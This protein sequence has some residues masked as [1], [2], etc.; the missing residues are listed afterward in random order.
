MKLSAITRRF[1]GLTITSSGSISWTNR[2]LSTAILTF[3]YSVPSLAQE[4]E[5]IKF[6]IAMV[7]VNIA[8]ND[9]NGRPLLG[10]RAEDF[11]VTDESSRVTPEFFDS[12]GPASIVFVVDTSASMRGARWK[13]LLTGLK[14]FLKKAHEGNDYTLIAFNNRAH[15]E[16]EAV[17]AAEFSKRLNELEPGGDTAMYDAMLLGLEALQRARHRHKALVLMSDGEDN[18]SSRG[19]VDIQ[20]EVMAR[21]TTIYAVGLLLKEFCALGIWEACRGKDTIK[22]MASVTGGVAHFPRSHELSKVLKD[23]GSDI[24]SQYSFSYYPPDKKPGWRRVQVTLAQT[25]RRSKLR[26]QERYLMR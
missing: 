4:A 3:F 20:R 14:E 21:R 15:V 8:V 17:T 2:L 25:E 24:S 7:T 11:L 16:A 10:L 22:E 1:V 13:S 19:L 5:V 12:A 26:Y 6:D 23:I 9:N 18:S